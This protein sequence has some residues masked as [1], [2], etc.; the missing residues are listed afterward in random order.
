MNSTTDRMKILINRLVEQIVI[1][2]L[3]AG[4]SRNAIHQDSTE[5]LCKTDKMCNKIEK[6]INELIASKGCN[7]NELSSWCKQALCEE[8]NNI[9]PSLSK[10]SEH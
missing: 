1:P 6:A 8:K 5:E 9:R 2:F 7:N 3:G 10:L 4:V